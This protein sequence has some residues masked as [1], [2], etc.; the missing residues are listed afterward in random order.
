VVHALRLL[1][2]RRLGEALR[3]RLQPAGVLTTPVGQQVGGVEDVHLGRVTET[4]DA[5]L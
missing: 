1:S 3:D 2:S 5:E 4:D